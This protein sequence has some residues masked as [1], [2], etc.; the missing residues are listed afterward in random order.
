MTSQS[1]R[2]AQ[3]A[4]ADEF[5]SR[6]RSDAEVAA[7]RLERILHDAE[8][9]AFFASRWPT[10]RLS[11]LL[12][13]AGVLGYEEWSRE[14]ER[15]RARDALARKDERVREVHERAKEIGYVLHDRWFDEHPDGYVERMEREALRRRSIAEKKRKE[16]ERLAQSAERWR[17]WAAEHPDRVREK[18]KRWAQDN[19]EHRKELARESY[20]RNREAIRA[21]QRE[22]NRLHPEKKAEYNRRYAQKHPDKVAENNRAWLEKPGNR[23]QH[24]EASKTWQRREQRRRKAGLPARRVHRQSAEEMLAGQAAADEFFARKRTAA[25]VRRMKDVR[26]GATPPDHLAAWRE[27]C[28][29]AKYRYRLA[30]DTAFRDRVAAA[31][32]RR[33]ER[34]VVTDED[35]RMDAIAQAIND[36]LRTTPRTRPPRPD[37]AAPHVVPSAPSQG[38]VGR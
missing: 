13:E 37:P 26:L 16:Q 12:D 20:A 30:T 4:T 7:I 11:R 1:D 33:T 21:R 22:F 2:A 10:E 25:E 32:R 14:S 18:A 3:Q 9:D 8:A 36:R 34:E 19:A 5:F 6:A 17:R 15:I 35:R 29:Q 38:G 23:E 27:E 31:E 24:R 28:R